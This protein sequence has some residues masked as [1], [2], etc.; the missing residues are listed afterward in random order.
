MGN[1]VTTVH[2]IAAVLFSRIESP[3]E[4]AA[5][6]NETGTASGEEGGLGCGEKK[7]KRGR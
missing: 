5:K 2:E 4:G 1:P 7:K 3:L 6:E